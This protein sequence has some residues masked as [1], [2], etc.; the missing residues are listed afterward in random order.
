[1]FNPKLKEFAEQKL[2]EASIDDLQQTME[3]GEITAKDLVFMYFDRIQKYDKNGVHL[4]S[5]LELNPEAVHIAEALDAERQEKGARGPLHGIPILL[6]DNIDTNDHLHTSAG[7]LALANNVATKDSFVAQ[8]LREAGAII[9]GK[10]NMTEWA[11]FMTENMPNGYSSRGGQVLNPYGPGTFDVGGSSSGSGASVAA[12]LVTVAIGTETSGSILSPA[13]SNSVVGIKP[14]VGLVSRSG[15]IPIS[16]SQD[17]AGPIGRTVKDAAHVL[18]AIAGVDRHDPATVKVTKEDFDYVTNIDKGIDGLRIGVA[19]DPYFDHLSEEE[20]KLLDEAIEELQKNGA[21]IIDPV[22]I[23]S[24]KEDWDINVLVYEFKPDLNAYLR[25]TS[26]DVKVRSLKDVIAFNEKYKEQALKHGQTMLIKSEET[27][28]TLTESEYLVS[29][30]KDQYL[31]KTEG[32]DA[33]IEE[34]NLDAVLFPNN[35]GAGIPSKAGYPSITVPA[36]YTDK[37]KPIG[38]TFTAKAFEEEKLIQIGYAYEQATKLRK[39][40]KLD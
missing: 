2:V 27:S 18:A 3:A 13:S 9:I 36:G 22:E 14:T 33:V 37:G 12:N 38:V 6:K 20:V 28:G 40:P 24:Q 10:A 1:M 30:E 25:N 26:A 19:R 35:L 4:N 16:H 5:V 31:A 15:I 21:T 8:K 39:E 17:T 32:I 11:N 34:N 23:P 7:S 29:L